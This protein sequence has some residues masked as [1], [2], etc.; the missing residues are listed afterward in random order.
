MHVKY[1][2]V[3]PSVGTRHLESPEEIQ[4][5]CSDT[6]DSIHIYHIVY[7]VHSYIYICWATRRGTSADQVHCCFL[8]TN[9]FFSQKTKQEDV[10]NIKTSNAE[11]FDQIDPPIRVL[12]YCLK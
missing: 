11:G 12:D 5:Y 6:T 1:S 4:M 9:L 3:S 7:E 8:L 10:N 2:D